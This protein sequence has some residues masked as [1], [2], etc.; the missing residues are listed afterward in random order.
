MKNAEI[1]ELMQKRRLRHYEV[2]AQI[3]ISETTF[4]VWLRSELTEERRAKVL[5]AIEDLG[6]V[7]NG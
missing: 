1:R 3:G 4:S 5:R 2:A 7:A 6:G